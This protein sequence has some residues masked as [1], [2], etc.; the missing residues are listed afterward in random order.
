MTAVTP[1]KRNRTI[2]RKID[3]SLYYERNLVERLFNKTKKF[4]AI[5]I[6]YDE[7]KFT[8]LTAVGLA[9]IIILLN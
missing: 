3:F 7:L 5:A 8:F 4:G 2:Q 6:R 9:S 1:S